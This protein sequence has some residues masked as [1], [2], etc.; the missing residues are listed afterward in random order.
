[1]RSLRG[2]SILLVED[3][4]DVRSVIEGLLA[5]MCARVVTASNGP[6][7]LALIAAETFALVVCDLHMPASSGVELCE[8]VRCAH[9]ETVVLAISG[10]L[11]EENAKALARLNV[12]FLAKPFRATALYGAV[13]RAQ[14]RQLEG[15]EAK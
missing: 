2:R 15:G 9:P 6:E 14:Q 7:G 3:D 13:E 1:M 12:D 8:S 10:Y 5:P 4:E 11:S